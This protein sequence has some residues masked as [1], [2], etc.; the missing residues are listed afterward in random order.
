MK[1]KN[2]LEQNILEQ[3]SYGLKMEILEL[4]KDKDYGFQ[5]VIFSLLWVNHYTT[6]LQ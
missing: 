1:Q 6:Q 5:I 2:I 4:M 3:V